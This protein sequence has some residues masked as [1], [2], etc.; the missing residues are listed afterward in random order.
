M[1]KNEKYHFCRFYSL[2][3]KYI[4]N[5]NIEHTWYISRMNWKW[6][7]ITKLID[8]ST[9]SIYFG[10]DHVSKWASYVNIISQ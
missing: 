9:I 4:L 10:K 5:N 2:E 1:V 7:D 3:N 8:Y 6:V